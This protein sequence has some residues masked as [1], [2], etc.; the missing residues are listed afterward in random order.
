[1]VDVFLIQLVQCASCNFVVQPQG[2]MTKTKA[3]IA[4]LASAIHANSKLVCIKPELVVVY[5]LAMVSNDIVAKGGSAPQQESKI[6]SGNGKP[7]DVTN[8]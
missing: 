3:E 6:V 4:A 1:M 2:I 7:V 5:T 8:N